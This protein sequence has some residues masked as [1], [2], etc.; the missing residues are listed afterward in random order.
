ME[1]SKDELY[2]LLLSVACRTGFLS[3]KWACALSAQEQQ[4]LQNQIAFLGTLQNKLTEG[5][6]DEKDETR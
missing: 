5:L 1:F 2:Q 3:Q 4:A 6:K